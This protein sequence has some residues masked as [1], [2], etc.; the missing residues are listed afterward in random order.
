M[1]FSAFLQVLNYNHAG[2]LTGKITF[3]VSLCIFF[4]INSL[5]K[6]NKTYFL[7]VTVPS[8]PP[9]PPRVY[10]Y[11]GV[12]KYCYLW[13]NKCLSLKVLASIILSKPEQ[14]TDNDMTT[15]KIQIKIIQLEVFQSS[16]ASSE[17][18]LW[19]MTVT[20]VHS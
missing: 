11:S 3:H 9:P 2:K 19:G 15:Y 4:T 12:S 8:P 14:L 6:K 16:L 10:M 17:H 5:L 18:I 7:G 1:E 13:A 20:P